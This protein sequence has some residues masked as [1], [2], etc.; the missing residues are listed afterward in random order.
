MGP[1]AR[2][3]PRQTGLLTVSGNFNFET[4]CCEMIRKIINMEKTVE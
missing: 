3:T 1:H 4:A 2:L